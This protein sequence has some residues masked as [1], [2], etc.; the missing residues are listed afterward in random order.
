M[1]R[2]FCPD[3]ENNPVMPEVESGHCIRVLRHQV[4]DLF[5]VVDGRGA[6]FTVRLVDA[7]PK[8]AMVEIV[9]R[10]QLPLYWSGK[11]VLAVAPTKNMDRMEWLIEKGTEVGFD[12]FVPLLCRYSERKEIKQERLEKTAV[13]AMKQSLKAFMPQIDEMTPFAD[14]IKEFR[15]YPQKFIAHCVDDGER[16]LLSRE[17]CPG[18]DTVVLI[19]PEGDFSTQEIEMA[20]NAGFVPVTLGDARLRTGTAALTAIETFHIV[21]QIKG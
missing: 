7:H 6:L 11:L 12:R 5:E 16:K 3:I 10:C 4:G 2:F 21:A 15:D 20:L 1:I 17:Y 14:F 18:Q 19:G 8:R 9:E 13:S